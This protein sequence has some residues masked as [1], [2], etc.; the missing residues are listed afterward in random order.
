[1]WGEQAEQRIPKYHN[2][3]ATFRG[4]AYFDC[5]DTSLLPWNTTKNGV[6]AESPLYKTVR[7]E[8][9]VLMRPVIDFLNEWDK[10]R[11]AGL[12]DAPLSRA[13]EVAPLTVITDGLQVTPL[14]KVVPRRTAPTG[15][16]VQRLQYDRPLDKVL[17][18]KETL[19]ASTF[20]Q[21]G[22]LTFDYYYE[23]E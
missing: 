23:L 16:R 14:F 21:V 8:M 7:E 2:Q 1:G 5:E 9:M 10:E 22:E 3:Y 20:K 17:K 11:T 13:V 19:K 6:D 4:V 15:V 18:A 12:D